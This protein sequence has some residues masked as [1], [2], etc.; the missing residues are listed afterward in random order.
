MRLLLLEDDK[1]LGDGL[2]GFLQSEGHRIDWYLRL[3]DVDALPLDGYDALLIDWQL[4]DG[5]GV[6]WIRAQRSLGIVQPIL[7]LTAR[8]LLADRV[9]GLD[10]GAD[11]Y[12]VKPFAPEELAARLRS[13]QRRRTARGAARL[14][15]GDVEFDLAAKAAFRGQDRIE[16]TAREWSLIEALASRAGRITSKAEL[17]ALVHGQDVGPASNVLEVHL[18]NVRRK[19]GRDVVRTVRGLGYRLNT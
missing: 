8:D 10:A 11:D 16:L 14:H 5:S 9:K 13:I 4:P 2:T 12:L 1:I 15:C 18:S 19:L 3:L 6:D 7:V 17:E